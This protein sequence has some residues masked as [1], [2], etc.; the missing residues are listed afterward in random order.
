YVFDASTFEIW[1]PLLH[2]GRIV[3]A[4]E[5]VLDA[6]ALDDA[7]HTHGATAVFMT[8][9]LFNVIAETDPGAFTGLRLVCAGGELASPDA[10]Q[11]VAALAPDTRVLHVYG[12]TETT[13]FATRYPVAAG[14][15]AG[16]PPIGRP[17]DGMR[18]HV[19]D[20]SLRPVPP[21]VVGEL[22]LA[23]HGVARGY[24]GRPGLTA[25]RFVADPFD[26][27][28]GRMYR[29]GDLVRWTPDGQI[30]Y[31]GRSDGQVKL[32]GYRIELGEIE[33]TLA[34]CQGVADAF[35]VVREDTP[36]DRRLVAYVVPASGAGPDPADL[37]RAVGRS[38]PAYMVP[39]AIVPLD[40][41]PLTPNGK[42]DRRALPVPE[43]APVSGRPA[44][45]AREEILCGLFA[46]VLGL[47]AAGPDDDF[48]ALG[49]HSLLATR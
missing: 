6:R 20:D 38:L 36:G 15:P 43:Y 22:Y 24:T 40:A 39:S 49:G 33:N 25:T 23:G 47:D 29:T 1:A 3:V 26:A 48:F 46:D 37:A 18:L 13:T 42:V 12:P 32:R 8:T 7:V 9:A 11:R 44:R 10:M 16:P 28:G 2:G 30:A 19:L 34:S 5:G 4:P 17:L 21:G 35:A 41:L 31:V 27:A 14:L 45:T